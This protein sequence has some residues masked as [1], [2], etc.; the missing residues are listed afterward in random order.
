MCSLVFNK[1]F[2]GVELSFS[3]QSPKVVFW[4]NGISP[5]KSILKQF[6]ISIILQLEPDSLICISDNPILLLFIIPVSVTIL[7]T[8]LASDLTL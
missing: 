5:L 8:C 6:S 7:S 2:F 1:T 4:T 3:S